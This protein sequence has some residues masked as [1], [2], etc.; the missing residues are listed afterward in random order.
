MSRFRLNGLRSIDLCVP[1]VSADARFYSDVW[2]LA[3]VA[4]ADGAAYFR[5]TGAYHHILALHPGAKPALLGITFDAHSRADVDALHAAVTAHGA[6]A[7]TQPAIAGDPAGGYGFSFRDPEG[8]VFRVVAEDA[9][10]ADPRTV[11]DRPERLSHIVLNSADAPR[12]TKFFVAA[13]G[14]KLSD[15]TKMMDFVRCNNDHHSIAFAN[16]KA[17][18]LHHIA[19]KM[20]S[21]DSV[22]RGAARMKDNGYPIE[23]GVGRHGPG[24]N[25][26]AYFVGPH[27]QPIEYT[28]EVEEVD[29]DYPVRGPDYWAFPAGRTDRWGLTPPPSARMHEAQQRYTFVPQA[30]HG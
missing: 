20:D 25:V 14:F 1:D 24:N 18:T 7:V 22:M 11:P 26:F 3:K 17:A 2:G 23:W 13:L 5:G 21:L 12:A 30:A 27:D 10:H 15:Q 8:R 28:S 19:F 4:E 29:D 9:R 16:G 6:T